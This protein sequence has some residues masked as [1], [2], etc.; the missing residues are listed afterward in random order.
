MPVSASCSVK[1]RETLTED[2]P[3]HK[4]WQEPR[5]LS[6]VMCCAIS[7]ATMMWAGIAHPA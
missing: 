5:L 7:S 4:A 1:A 6:M 3:D 2:N